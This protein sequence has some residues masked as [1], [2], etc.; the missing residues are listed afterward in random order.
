VNQSELEATFERLWL[1]LK[2]EMPAPR[3]EYRFAPPRRWRFD[4]SWVAQK[5]AVELQGGTWS[6]S[7][8]GHNR[9]SMIERDCEKLN[10]AQANG[11]TVFYLTTSMLDDDPGRW[12]DMI[13]EA[14]KEATND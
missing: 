13:A 14:I 2:P 3:A 4:F 1:L 7:R 8:R 6:K 12:L 5:V 11:W 9:G 10:A